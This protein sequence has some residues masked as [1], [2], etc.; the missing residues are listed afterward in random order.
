M[1]GSKAMKPKRTP[2]D[3]ERIAS[4]VIEGV[5]TRSDGLRALCAEHGVSVGRF[6]DWV[7][8]SP[9]LAERYARAKQLQAELLAAEI[10]AIADESEVVAQYQGEQVKLDLSPTAIQR[11]RLRV[12]ARKWVASKL[13]PKVYGDKIAVGG[14]DDLPPVQVQQTIDPSKLSS[15]ALAE[16]LAAKNGSNPG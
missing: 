7:D 15:A 5:A 11:N 8:S 16:I 2:E 9:E 6:M 13:L 10:V 4:L 14:A 1:M 12:D 3:R